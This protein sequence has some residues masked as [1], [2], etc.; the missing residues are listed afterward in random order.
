MDKLTIF[1]VD[2]TELN[3]AIQRVGILE[4]N[5]WI[6]IINTVRRKV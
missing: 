1:N 6:H 3:L 4:I 2:P 5:P